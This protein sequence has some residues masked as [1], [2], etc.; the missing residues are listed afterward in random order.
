MDHLLSV[1]FCKGDLRPMSTKPALNS[2]YKRASGKLKKTRGYISSPHTKGVE[3]EVIYTAYREYEANASQWF[4]TSEDKLA[5]LAIS[6]RCPV[7]ATL[8]LLGRLISRYLGLSW[9]CY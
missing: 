5:T 8:S 3:R 4:T 1:K 7:L 6:F 2:C 9:L